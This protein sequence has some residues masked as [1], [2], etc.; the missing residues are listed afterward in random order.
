MV[1]ALFASFLL[2]VG[3]SDEPTTRPLPD[4]AARVMAIVDQPDLSAD[5]LM[6]AMNGIDF[7]FPKRDQSR[8]DDPEYVAELV[9]HE[10]MLRRACA[11]LQFRFVE[12]YPEDNRS[13]NVL[14]WAIRHQMVAL[15]PFREEPELKLASIRDV[16]APLREKYGMTSR[17]DAVLSA[18]DLM[19]A[20]Q[21]SDVSNDKIVATVDQLRPRVPEL[22]ILPELLLKAADRSEDEEKLRLTRKAAEDFPETDDGK[23]ALGKLRR[24]EGVGQQF[25]F[26]FD[27]LL[28]GRRVSS[29]SLK[30]NIVVVD[31]WATWCVPCVEEMPRMK[32]IYEQFH[33]K[34]VEFIGIS[35]DMPAEQGGREK[36]IAFLK[37]NEVPWPQTYDGMNWYTPLALEW[38]IPHIPTIFVVDENGKLV[39]R[40]AGTRLEEILDTLIK[41][42]N[43]QD[44]DDRAKDV[45]RLLKEFDVTPRP[46]FDATR[47]DA[48]A[49]IAAW[50]KEDEI[51][52]QRQSELAHQI[53]ELDPTHERAPELLRVRLNELL[54]DDPAV[55]QQLRFE[56]E[57]IKAMPGA[58]ELTKLVADS[59]V[60]YSL[61]WGDAETL[62][63]D[64]VEPLVMDI[65]RR[66][67]ED[68]LYAGMAPRLIATLM[69]K[70]GELGNTDKV[71]EFDAR[72]QELY[73][74][75]VF[76]LIQREREV[77]KALIGQPLRLRFTDVITGQEIDTHDYRGQPVVVDFW[78][79]WCGPC[80]VAL[81]EFKQLHADFAPR[82]VA[83]VGASLDDPGDADKI[84]DFAQANDL[85]WPQY[86][87]AVD[88]P[89]LAEGELFEPWETPVAKAWVL[90]G[91]PSVYVL[92][93]EGKLLSVG[94]AR[95]SLESHF[96][97]E[98]QPVKK[99]AP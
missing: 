67:P 15:G 11:A 20:I 77:R 37:E 56:A 62:D 19:Y 29:A 84:K 17:F 31:F 74:D 8:D 78:A 70:H 86:H 24:M 65:A 52:R 12:D 43:E 34:G 22:S 71:T 83:F 92:D 49:Y 13:A 51:A 7:R 87:L 30:G 4:E 39:D 5:E 66:D 48:E 58:S 18:M 73:P 46:A 2:L 97:E 82:G 63:L 88:V 99:P 59:F 95:E 35:L 72:L 25:D 54:V 68:T 1:T 90:G 27:D 45:Q 47:S 93:A 55:R 81:P 42:R 38:G 69:R 60:A 50:V 33:A 89:A 10:R 75:S 76:A 98:K 23:A 61:L 14:S 57:A 41:V 21:Y 40:D 28:T 96:A 36:L 16:L 32:R 9:R 85:P 80:I 64:A 53:L 3:I 44:V 79:T 26:A 91:I 6:S 94:D